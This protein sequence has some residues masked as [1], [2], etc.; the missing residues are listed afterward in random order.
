MKTRN[1][2]LILTKEDAKKLPVGSKYYKAIYLDELG[3]ERIDTIGRFKTIEDLNEYC[4]Q[5]CYDE[6]DDYEQAILIITFEIIDN[7]EALSINKDIVWF[8]CIEEDY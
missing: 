8:G 2:N 6:I 5:W 7:G 4:Q 1:E 3:E